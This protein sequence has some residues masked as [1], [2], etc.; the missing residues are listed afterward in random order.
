MLF[1]GVL[2]SRSNFVQLGEHDTI[3]VVRKMTKDSRDNSHCEQSYQKSIQGPTKYQTD[4]TRRT[5][6]RS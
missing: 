3:Q 4:L 6:H 2:N 5:K 1:V